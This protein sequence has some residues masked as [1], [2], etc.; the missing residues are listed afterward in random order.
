MAEFTLPKNSKVRQGKTWPAPAGA[1]RVRKFRV[2][3]YDPDG[4]RM[5]TAEALPIILDG[6]RRRGF[7]FTTL[8]D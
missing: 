8:P 5:Q 4:D 6:L 7:R 3:R 1:K 2:Y